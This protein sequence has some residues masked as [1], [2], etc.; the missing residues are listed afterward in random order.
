MA[1][2]AGVGVGVGGGVTGIDGGSGCVGAPRT[3]AGLGVSVGGRSPVER[4]VGAGAVQG[5]L[6]PETKGMSQ[7]VARVCCAVVTNSI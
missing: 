3:G 2:G 4:S 6:H 1:V 5:V 7:N